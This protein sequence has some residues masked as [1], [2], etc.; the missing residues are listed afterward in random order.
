MVMGSRCP[1]GHVL[2]PRGRDASA[3]RKPILDTDQSAQLRDQLLSEID[4]L[5]S[6]EELT[7]WARRILN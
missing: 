3:R 1:R 5:A 7:A 4:Q 2:P 6:G